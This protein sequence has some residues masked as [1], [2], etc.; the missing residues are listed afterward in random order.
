MDGFIIFCFVIAI[1]FGGIAIAIK[2][3]LKAQEKK[4]QQAQE[5]QEKEKYD[6]MIKKI[7]ESTWSFPVEV[8]YKKCNALK[9][10]P[11]ISETI[12]TKSQAAVKEILTELKIPEKYHDQYL[13]EQ[14]IQ[15]YFEE[16]EKNEY[17]KIVRWIK[18]EFP[19]HQIKEIS[20]E[21]EYQKARLVMSDI[22]KKANVNSYYRPIYLERSKI[23]ECFL[24]ADLKKQ[25]EKERRHQ[26]QL[27]KTRKAEAL[28]FEEHSKDLE[29]DLEY[30]G[31][32]KTVK[33]IQKQIAFFESK[34]E[35]CK[36]EYERALHETSAKSL[37]YDKRSNNWAYHGGIASA[38]AGPAAGIMMASEAKKRED[39]ANQRNAELSAI[40]LQ[41]FAL[42]AQ[43]LKSEEAELGEELHCWKNALGSTKYQLEEWQDSDHL[44]KIL[45]PKVKYYHS[46]E[47]GAVKLNISFE[48]TV[49]F[50]IYGEKRAYIDGSVLVEFWN[51]NELCG[52]AI[53]CLPYG[54]TSK[55]CESKCFC[56]QT[57]PLNGSKKYSIRFKPNKLWAMEYTDEIIETMY[58]LEKYNENNS[59]I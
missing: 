38:I 36:Q 28:L 45:S 15:S 37:K 29:Y 25:E 42:K 8:F 30:I 41:L 33:Y 3:A 50:K 17:N 46:S 44:L 48:K 51:N 58:R 24:A 5:A 7:E 43:R 20:N 13:T 40:N 55:D 9:I 12:I 34:I 22:L 16:I 26:R 47:T 6:H 1:I 56:I 57:Q 49:D 10:T 52:S 18:N 53:C 31:K 23:E 32:E 14:K 21:A 4:E 11:P 35:E 27:E 2:I 19:K 54:G 59:E 39:E